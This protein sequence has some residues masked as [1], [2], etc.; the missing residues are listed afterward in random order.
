MSRFI[1]LLE[2]EKIN[3][4]EKKITQ[5]GKLKANF[6]EILDAAFIDILEKKSSLFKSMVEKGVKVDFKKAFEF[7]KES[8]SGQI[9]ELIDDY[10]E[11]MK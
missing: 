4:Q 10:Q 1:D 8:F 7:P 2:G 9:S 3:T 6:N 11:D 5:S